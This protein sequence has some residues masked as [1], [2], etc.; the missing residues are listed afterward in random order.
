MGRKV[1]S[2]T[3]FLRGKAKL[4]KGYI[5]GT[6]KGYVKCGQRKYPNLQLDHSRWV[7]TEDSKGLMLKTGKGNGDACTLLLSCTVI[8]LMHLTVIYQP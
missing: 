3:G 1:A 8:Q 5:G 7:A 4:G 2:A 6:E